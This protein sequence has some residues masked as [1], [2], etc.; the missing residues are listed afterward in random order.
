MPTKSEHLAVSAL[1]GVVTVLA[2]WCLLLNLDS[3]MAVSAFG[4]VVASTFMISL[5]NL[6]CFFQ[7]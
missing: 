1:A 6:I 3:V 2:T 7:R 4:T 5:V